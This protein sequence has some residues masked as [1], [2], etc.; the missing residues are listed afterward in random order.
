M[1]VNRRS[2]YIPVQSGGGLCVRQHGVFLRVCYFGRKIKNTTWYVPVR[3][4]KRRTMFDVR[5]PS[6]LLLLYEKVAQDSRGVA[7]G[8]YADVGMRKSC[9]SDVVL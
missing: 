2:F 1:R 6:L 8:I 9:C 3:H 5:P 4:K 7:A